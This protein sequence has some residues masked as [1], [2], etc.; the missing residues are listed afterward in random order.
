MNILVPGKGMV[1]ASALRVETAVNRYDE[2]LHFGFN[3]VN[4]DWIIYVKMDRDFDSQYHIDGAPVY[5]VLGFQDRIPEPDEAIE[6]LIKADV[7]RNPE[8]LDEMN[9]ENERTRKEQEEA[10]N[11]A[12]E[13]TAERIEFEMRKQ[14]FTEKYAHIPMGGRRKR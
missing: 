12:L 9:K 11:E 4:R 6:R 3:E 13:E 7:W 14:G 5:P 10:S 8:R 2:R 1:N